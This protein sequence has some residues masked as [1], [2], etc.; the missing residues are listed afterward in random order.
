MSTHRKHLSTTTEKEIQS[1][2]ERK[3]R[4]K[5]EPPKNA[6]KLEKIVSFR[7]ELV[8]LHNYLWVMM[9]QDAQTPVERYGF[10]YHEKILTLSRALHGLALAN[11]RIFNANALDVEIVKGRTDLLAPLYERG[12]LATELLKLKSFANKDPD[13]GSDVE[14]YIAGVRTYSWGKVIK[15]MTSS[16]D[17]L[18]TL[19]QYL[20][21]DVE[22]I[23]NWKS[24]YLRECSVIEKYACGCLG[25]ILPK[26]DDVDPGSFEDYIASLSSSN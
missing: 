3:K 18:K 24:E 25:L 2:I 19:V 14:E 23:A 22:E 26:C 15:N 5:Q 8:R 4:L 10:V 7:E 21:P 13:V 9:N 12:C 1:I 16:M 17:R 11:R 20:D 6:L